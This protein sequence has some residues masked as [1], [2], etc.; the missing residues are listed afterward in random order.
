[1][2]AEAM[3]A[4]YVFA[5]Q[6]NPVARMV[7]GKS[8]WAVPGLTLLVELVTQVHYRECIQPE[9]DLSPLYKDVFRFHWQEESQHA[10]LDKLE[11]RREDEKLDARATRRS[12]T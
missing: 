10:I 3:L 11:W 5:A 8:T 6:P 4:G 12:T 7:L 1:M 9:A 2:I